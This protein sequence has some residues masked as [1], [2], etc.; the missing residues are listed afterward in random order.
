MAISVAVPPSA[1]ARV[2]GIESKFQNL[3][4]GR[5]TALP[6]R[7]VIVGQGATLSTYS[8]DKRQFFTSFDVGGAYG[9]GSPVHL[10]S[11]QFLPINGDGIG[12]IPLTIYPLEDEAA[13]VASAGDIIPVV[14]SISQANYQVSI[15]NILSEAFTVEVGDVAADIIA[16]MITAVNAVVEMPM[17]ASDGTTTTDFTSKWKGASAND[18]YLEIIGPT[19]AG[20]TWTITQPVGGATN[21]NAA[22]INAALGQMGNVWETMLLNCL[23]VADTAALDVYQG[24]VEGRRGPLVKKPLVVFSGDTNTTVAAATAVPDARKSDGANSQL[25]SPGSNDLPFI[26]A[27]RQMA[28]IVK[29][30]NDTPPHNY[31]LQKATGLTPGPDGVQ[32]TYPERDTA[33]KK[34]SSTV[35]IV[36]NV[37]AISDVVTFYH[38]TGQTN[39]EFRYVV[40]QVKT[41]QVIFNLGLIFNSPGWAGA[42]LV[43]DDQAVTEPTAK[44]PKMAKAAVA[45]MIDS[46][47]LAAIISDPA[48]AK[49]TIVAAINETNPKRLDISFTYAISGNTSIISITANY[50]FFFGT[51]PIVG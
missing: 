33:V 35:E 29:L 36:D 14:G 44:K 46:L 9:F 50:G 51:A 22:S 16:K 18:L 43:P 25:V 37:V 5:A 26:V 4:G 49:E 19:D 34:G 31:D 20:M 2:V 27:A 45:N 38:P 13:S 1:V 24:F 15:N 17:I 6:Q 21:P 39:P 32:W 41:W 3:A 40:D 28:R 11:I 8:L 10:A 42:P 47:A 7:A 48:T 23:D 12:I 30:A